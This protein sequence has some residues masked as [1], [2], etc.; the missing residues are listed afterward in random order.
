MGTSDVDLKALDADLQELPKPKRGWFARNW[1]WFLPVLVLLIIVAGGGGYAGWF[2]HKVFGNEASRHAMSKIAE[3]KDI[4]AALGEPIKCLYLSPTPS[5]RQDASET[6]IHWT[7]VGS[8]EKQAKVHIFRRLMNGKWETVTADVTLPD[9]KKISLIG[10]D[11]GEVAP[12][13]NPQP[14]PTADA[15]PGDKAAGKP[16]DENM[17][18][19]ISPNIPPPEESK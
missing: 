17:P 6:D 13:F 15:K 11:E 3:N 12:P 5:I 7:I 8:S 1:K 18:E 4:V 9:G 19:D 16:A 10:D 2:Y 14:P